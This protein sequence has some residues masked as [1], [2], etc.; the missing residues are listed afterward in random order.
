MI[1]KTI[2]A[3]LILLLCFSFVSCLDTDTVYSHCELTI[4]LADNFREIENENFDV[5]YTDG[6]SAVAILRISFEAGLKSGISNLMSSYE[7]GEFWLERC[8]RDASVVKE[9]TVY[10][11]YY[12]GEQYY[13]ETFYRSKDAY[14]VVLFA[15]AAKNREK[16][17]GKYLEYAEG[18][19]FS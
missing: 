17:F 10:C 7:F 18:V 19:K 4:P 6:E 1:K 15:T 9:G 2:S 5:T 11:E 13:L 14:F 12:D 8:E 3:T 16:N